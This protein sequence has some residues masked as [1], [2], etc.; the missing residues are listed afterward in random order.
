ME[1]LKCKNDVEEIE[2]FKKFSCGKCK[3]I[4]DINELV[5]FKDYTSY[6]RAKPVDIVRIIKGEKC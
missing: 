3:I 6:K 5:Y 2:D 4:W 1:C